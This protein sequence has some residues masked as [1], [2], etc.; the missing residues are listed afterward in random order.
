MENNLEQYEYNNENIMKIIE[1]LNQ[2]P[3]KEGIPQSPQEELN[4]MSKEVRSNNTRLRIE[5]IKKRDQEPG[6]YITRVIQLKDAIMKLS[7]TD[8]KKLLSFSCLYDDVLQ[9]LF[10]KNEEL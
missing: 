10:E 3:T 4:K 8:I 7:R 5:E 2:I 6:V 1:I 9:H